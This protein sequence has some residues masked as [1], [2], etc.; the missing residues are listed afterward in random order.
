MLAK[1]SDRFGSVLEAHG[2]FISISQKLGFW[3]HSQDPFMERFLMPGHFECQL[4][5]FSWSVFHYLLLS[6]IPELRPDD[7]GLLDRTMYDY[8]EDEGRRGR[9]STLR[10]FSGV[11]HQSARSIIPVDAGYLAEEAICR[12]EDERL[13]L[14]MFLN[15]VL[16]Q[17]EVRWDN[18]SPSAYLATLALRNKLLDRLTLERSLRPWEEQN[19]G[20]SHIRSDV[21]SPH[22]WQRVVRRAE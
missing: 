7:D 6:A 16:P 19:L 14:G 13:Y 20:Y 4:H 18:A 17:F 21:F 12:I 22:V 3:K 5:V 8:R 9:T 2:P 1:R 15:L 11:V 10:S